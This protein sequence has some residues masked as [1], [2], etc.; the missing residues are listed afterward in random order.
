MAHP[1]AEDDDLADRVAQPDDAQHIQE[2]VHMVVHIVVDGRNKEVYLVT[3]D[4]RH[5]LQQKNEPPKPA[6][7]YQHLEVVVGDGLSEVLQ[8]DVFLGSEAH[9]C[10]HR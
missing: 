7:S 2:I 5:R 10:S 1:A 8:F 9:Q 4:E 6:A 3:D